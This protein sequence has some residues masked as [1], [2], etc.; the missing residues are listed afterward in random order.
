M[1]NFLGNRVVCLRV[2]K[3]GSMRGPVVWG[4]FGSVL[5]GLTVGRPTIV[6]PSPATGRLMR[7]TGRVKPTSA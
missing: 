5:S 2:V 4:R 7:S 3:S 6:T 1:K